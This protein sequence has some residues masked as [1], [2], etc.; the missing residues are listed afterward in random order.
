MRALL[1]RTASAPAAA[2]DADA[3]RARVGAFVFERGTP[4]APGASPWAYVDDP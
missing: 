1:L 2:L 3:R 4:T